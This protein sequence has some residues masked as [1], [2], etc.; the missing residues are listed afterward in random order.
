[1][2]KLITMMALAGALATAYYVVS[3]VDAASNLVQ[4]SYHV[5]Y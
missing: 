1:M 5:S 3:C 2:H 4:Q